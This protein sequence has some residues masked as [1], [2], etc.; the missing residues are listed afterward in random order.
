VRDEKTM[1]VQG[2]VIAGGAGTGVVAPGRTLPPG[3]VDA[4]IGARVMVDGIA[5]TIFGFVG[6][7]SPQMP[8]K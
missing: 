4:G 2:G 7:Y 1:V 3:C 5:Y 8:V 6:I